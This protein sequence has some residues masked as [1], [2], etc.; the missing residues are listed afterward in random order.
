MTSYKIPEENKV[1][2]L[3]GY[4]GKQAFFEAQGG[5]DA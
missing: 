3:E 2:Q 4:L 1:W 5:E